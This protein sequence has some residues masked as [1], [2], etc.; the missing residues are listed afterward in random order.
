MQKSIYFINSLN[1]YKND[2]LINNN[3]Y[4]YYLIQ[5]Y[6]EFIYLFKMHNFELKNYFNF[7]KKIP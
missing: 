4:H 6:F 5:I 2:Y 1:N 7:V 3:N